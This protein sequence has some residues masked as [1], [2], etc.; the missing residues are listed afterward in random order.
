M[1]KWKPVD[2]IALIFTLTIC[3]GFLISI[4]IPA[5]RG[6]PMSDLKAKIIH[7]LFTAMISV[8]SLFIGAKI[9]YRRGGKPEKD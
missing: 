2:W 4:S 9:G 8:V 6:V 1:R 3:I 7:N 5:V